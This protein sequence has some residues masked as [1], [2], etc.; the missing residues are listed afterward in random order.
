MGLVFISHA[1]TDKPKLRALFDMLHS[2]DVSVWLDD[3]Q[4]FGGTA[5][6]ADLTRA[7]RDSEL[8]IIVCTKASF[9]SMAVA[10]EIALAWKY[11]KKVLPVFFE[12]LEYPDQLQFFLGDLQ[13]IAWYRLSMGERRQRID[14]ALQRL[15]ASKQEKSTPAKHSN[16]AA[17]TELFDLASLKNNL[18]VISKVAGLNLGERDVGHA[19]TNWRS[20]IAIGTP[21]A[22]AITLET[23]AFVTLLNI[24]TSGNVNLICPGQFAPEHYFAAG[25]TI[26]PTRNSCSEAMSLS[27][28]PGIERLLALVT[29]DE[30]C[31]GSE[32]RRQSALTLNSDAVA[33]IADEFRAMPT[34][35][36]YAFGFKVLEALL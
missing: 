5:W 35:M 30:L 33:A 24:G 16:L 10:K 6:A 29:P 34:S 1:A 28:P 17:I 18:T 9:K 19:S 23:A 32:L 11:K 8:V 4:L 26:V 27:G 3:K 15:L 12:K 13:H 25:T 7:V 22:V 21:I 31:A 14:A 2:L 20:A 36:A